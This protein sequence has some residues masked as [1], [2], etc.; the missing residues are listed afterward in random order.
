MFRLI[1]DREYKTIHPSS[2]QNHNHNHSLYSNGIRRG[3][4]DIY[5]GHDI[6]QYKMSTFRFLHDSTSLGIFGD[7]H[8]HFHR[9]FPGFFVGFVMSL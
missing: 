8:S 7:T 6:H 4:L 3:H 2:S 5:M 9:C 1:E